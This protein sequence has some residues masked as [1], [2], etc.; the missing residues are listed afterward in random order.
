MKTVRSVENIQLRRDLARLLK[1]LRGIRRE[2]LSSSEMRQRVNSALAEVG[3][4]SRFVTVENRDED[5]SPPHQGWRARVDK[6]RLDAA[7]NP[8]RHDGI[9]H[10]SSE[11][12]TT[13]V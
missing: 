4:L 6:A 12:V 8:G 11:L 2:K 3:S 7:E 13:S 1:R 9:V 5:S 10:A